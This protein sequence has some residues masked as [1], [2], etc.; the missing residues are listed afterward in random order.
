MHI[1]IVSKKEFY[2]YVDG[3][4][5][6]LSCMFEGTEAYFYDS[7]IGKG[8]MSTVAIRSGDDGDFVYK[9]VEIK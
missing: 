4:P 7:D 6:E 1:K 5:K 2:D 3:Y 8:I 9:I